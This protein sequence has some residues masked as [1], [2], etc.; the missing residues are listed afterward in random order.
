MFGTFITVSVISVS[1]PLLLSPTLIFA[2]SFSGELFE[3][4][5]SLLSPDSPPLL[6]VF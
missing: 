5:C 1:E 6:V 2:K 4:M 3:E